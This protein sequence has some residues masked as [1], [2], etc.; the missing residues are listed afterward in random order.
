MT[1][2]TN[3][4]FLQV[5]LGQIREDPFVDLV[6]AKS[7]LVSS[8]PK[9]RSQTK[10]SMTAPTIKSWRASSAAVAR[11]SRTRGWAHGNPGRSPEGGTSLTSCGNG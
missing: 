3:A 11:V 2:R 6:V 5:L 9:L 7:R 1:N 8:R 10:T 4:D